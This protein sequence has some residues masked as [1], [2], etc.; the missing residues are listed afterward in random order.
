VNLHFLYG[1]AEISGVLDGL[2]VIDHAPDHLEP[3]GDAF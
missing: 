3:V 2:K 1:G